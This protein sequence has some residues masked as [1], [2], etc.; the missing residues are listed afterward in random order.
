[1]S[2]EELET[3]VTRMMKIG[4]SYSPSFSP[5][6]KRLSFVSDLNGIP[7]VWTVAVDG[8]WPELV[9]SLNDPV[10]MVKWSPRRDWLGFSVAPGGGMNT[11]VYII[12]PD[13]SMIQRLTDGGKETNLLGFWSHDGR[14]IAIGSNRSNPEA[15]DAYLIDSENGDFRLVAKNRGVGYL[16]DVSRDCRKAVLFRLQNRGDNDLY[17][18]NLEK[19]TET[20]ITPHKGPGTFGGGLFSP[21]GR[22]IYITSNKDREMTAFAKIEVSDIGEPGQI[23]VLSQRDDAELEFIRISPD[24]KRAALVWNTAGRSELCLLDLKSLEEVHE[25]KIPAEIVSGITFSKDGRYLAIT[26]SGSTMPLDIWAYDISSNEIWQIT[27]SSHSGVDLSKLT[28]PDLVRFRAADSLD[29]SGWLYTPE[30]YMSP[31]PLVLSFHGGPESQERPRFNAGYQ[32]L[33]ARGIAV[34]A[35]NVRGSAGFGKTFV[36][37]DNGALRFDTIRDIKDCWDVMVQS[38]VADPKCVGIM[39]GSY[40]GYMTMAGLTVYPELFASGVNLFGIVNFETFF[41]NTELWMAAI[42]KIEYGDPETESELLRSLSPIH[43]IDK[44]KSPTLVLHGANDTNVPVV[45]AEQVVTNL[46]NRGIPCE[47]T[48]YPDEGHGFR[49]I[50]NR[51]DS[52]MAV[53]IWFEKYL[54]S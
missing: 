10:V 1:M 5:D 41:A 37:L 32:T 16:T 49:K 19:K 53:T 51:I 43:K 30:E 50:S 17:L 48:L 38:G 6:G 8:G 12:R 47:Y 25:L 13:G 26:I 14:E 52:A 11:Q 34:F 40:G 29:L 23:E 45:E 3:L 4:S 18:V 22:T 35:P 21:D 28:S 2:S 31:G 36:N 44:V 7:Q 15:I 54:K 33:L 27:H 20:N 24:G 42:S 46:R 9:T 39:G